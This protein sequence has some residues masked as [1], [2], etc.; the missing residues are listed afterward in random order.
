MEEPL[1][2][3]LQENASNEEHKTKMVRI[4]PKYFSLLNNIP[5]LLLMFN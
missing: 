5:C 4:E 2:E 1:K 3:L